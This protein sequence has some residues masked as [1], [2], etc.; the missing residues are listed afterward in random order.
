M[1]KKFDNEVYLLALSIP[2]KSSAEEVYEIFKKLETYDN[3]CI[4]GN[5]LLLLVLF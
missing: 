3:Q 1:A 2:S 5:F 4:K